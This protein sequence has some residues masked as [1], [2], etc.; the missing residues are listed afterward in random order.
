[1]IKV[2]RYG[3]ETLEQAEKLYQTQFKRDACLSM[4]HALQTWRVMERRGLKADLHM[5]VKVETD[6]KRTTVYAARRVPTAGEKILCRLNAAAARR[7]VQ[8]EVSAGH[9]R[10]LE[11]DD[12][13]DTAGKAVKYGE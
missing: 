10:P 1:M 5:Y 6:G 7:Y 9:M 12:Q 2:E 11:L 8:A 4:E 13:M 3:M